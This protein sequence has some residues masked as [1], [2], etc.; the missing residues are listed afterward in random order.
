MNISLNRSKRVEL[1]YSD[2]AVGGKLRGTLVRE[3]F[4][5]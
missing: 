4:P 2:K 1:S 3:V 5:R